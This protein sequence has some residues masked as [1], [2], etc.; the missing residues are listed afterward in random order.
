M[1]QTSSESAIPHDSKWPAGSR[2]TLTEAVDAA[3]EIH[4]AEPESKEANVV[5]VDPEDDSTAR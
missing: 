4:P 1:T 2:H 5:I 3:G